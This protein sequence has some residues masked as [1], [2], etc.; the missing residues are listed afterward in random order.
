MLNNLNLFM[1]EENNLNLKRD[2]KE[3]LTIEQITFLNQVKEIVN[4]YE[5][6]LEKIGDFDVNEFSL[7]FFNYND[8]LQELIGDEL[9]NQTTLEDYSIALSS[10]EVPIKEI[11]KG[12]N[13][14][15]SYEAINKLAEFYNISLYKISNRC[16]K[17]SPIISEFNT[18][19]D[20]TSNKKIFAMQYLEVEIKRIKM[21]AF[22]QFS[23][24]SY[25]KKAKIRNFKYS[26]LL[27][28]ILNQKI[29]AMRLILNDDLEILKQIL[30][31]V[32]YGFERTDL[33]ITF[34]SS[35]IFTLF[36]DFIVCSFKYLDEN[37]KYGNLSKV[38]KEYFLL[39]ISYNGMP[40]LEESEMLKLYNN[41]ELIISKDK[42]SKENDISL[43]KELLRSIQ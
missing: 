42:Y 26:S 15:I 24:S 1:K 28:N 2:E 39:A 19:C 9:Y 37:I 12:G 8:R 5:D 25:F 38:L 43:C 33:G 11:S 32:I 14:K 27:I 18:I 7:L 21:L 29:Y 4:A 6:E 40:Y 13:I 10:I 20:L 30:D 34:Q 35:K 22:K 16:Y 17:N 23:N 31:I 36:V 41:F 3:V